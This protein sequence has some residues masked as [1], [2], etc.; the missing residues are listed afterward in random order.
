MRTAAP[1]DQ[2]TL[3]STVSGKPYSW[4]ESW[5]N[6]LLGD[7]EKKRNQMTSDSTKTQLQMQR[8]SATRPPEWNV[9]RPLAPVEGQRFLCFCSALKQ[10]F[11]LKRL[12][13]QK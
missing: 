1:K 7:T 6:P 10:K 5:A 2:V 4:L 3:T 8:S 11:L 12:L 13:K 9:W